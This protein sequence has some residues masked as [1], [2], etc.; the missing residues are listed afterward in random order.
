LIKK[1]LADLM[2][3]SR[4][5]LQDSII[6]EQTSIV[7]HSVQTQYPLPGYS[8]A[9]RRILTIMALEGI[10]STGNWITEDNLVL[11]T[12]YY[13]YGATGIVEQGYGASSSQT[14]YTGIFINTA[15]FKDGTTI[16][17]RYRYQNPD[18]RP[19]LTNFSN[20]SQLRKILSAILNNVHLDVSN[21]SSTI[22]S[23]GIEAKGNDLDRVVG[24]AGIVRTT[25]SYTTG[26]V[27]VVN[28]S[29]T[30][31]FSVTSGT[32]FT[33][34]RG[35]GY[36]NFRSS[37]SI[38]ISPLTTAI[39]Q[40]TSNEIGRANNVGPYAI[41][42]VYLSDTLN[43]KAPS[44]IVVS[45]PPILETTENYFNNGSDPEGDI[46]LKER[47]LT[48][49]K[50]TKTS[51][52]ATIKKAIEDT[53]LVKDVII[54]DINNRKGISQFNVI[55]VIQ[56]LSGTPLTP[57]SVALVQNAAIDVMPAGI[58]L[59]IEQTMQSYISIVAVVSIPAINLI[60]TSSVTTN[61]ENAI[62]SYI[63]GL[64][65][66][67]DIYPSNI[68][69][70]IVTV[71]PVVDA[72][73]TETTIT[74]Y[75]SETYAVDTEIE[76]SNSSGTEQNRIALQ[77]PFNSVVQREVA[78]YDGTNAYLNVTNTPIDERIAPRVNKSV[79]DHLG[80]NRPSPL[81]RFDFFSSVSNSSSRINF[82]PTGDTSDPIVNGQS[83]YY[84]YNHYDN[85]TI[86]GIRILLGGVSG[87]KVKVELRTGSNV[88]TATLVH[89]DTQQTITLDSESAKLYTATFT[90]PVTLTPQTNTYWIYVT[91]DNSNVN[92]TTIWIDSTNQYVAMNPQ[93]WVDGQYETSP[94]APNGT[95]Q[96]KYIRGHYH[97]FTKNVATVYQ[98]IIIPT[99]SFYPESSKLL[100]ST[101]TYVEANDQ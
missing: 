14:I 10:S 90:N 94:G 75:V 4:L 9:N 71:N 64:K 41:T 48:A 57:T 101:I 47:Y 59:K 96:R 3:I 8:T 12:D 70:A 36:I 18:F 37:G 77:L 45:N 60:D 81:N 51:S 76:L 87:Q 20:D 95:H 29:S 31:S 32:V 100:S 46:P 53:N 22:D 13:P 24:L 30:N 84:D 56:S 55:A 49:V 67:E 80:L 52:S 1:S 66:G 23:F 11:N 7:Y 5:L 62:N 88:D 39:F 50:A 85:R 2:E 74:E 35:G 28:S 61:I 83:V 27:Q 89:A 33:A 99:R 72:Q 42:E 69:A 34:R 98:K 40:V 73:L 6:E 82:N 58:R 19:I 91:R 17:I 78:N 21:L 86:H 15:I 92:K 43:E 65:L 97:S 54:Q 25:G 68:I 26:R 93:F 38:N 16:Y 63:N 44:Y 79:V